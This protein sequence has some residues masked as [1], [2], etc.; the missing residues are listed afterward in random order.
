MYGPRQ[1]GDRLAVSPICIVTSSQLRV[2]CFDCRDRYFGGQHESAVSDQLERGAS[3]LPVHCSQAKTY[4]TRF[5]FHCE[6][7]VAFAPG[8]PMREAAFLLLLLR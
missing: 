7:V 5:H 4:D 6:Y 2:E 8:W 1:Q 3:P